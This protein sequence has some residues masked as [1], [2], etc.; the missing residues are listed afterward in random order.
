MKKHKQHLLAS[1]AAEK[2]PIKLTFTI[3]WLRSTDT[4]TRNISTNFPRWFP[5][6]CSIFPFTRLKRLNPHS[7]KVEQDLKHSSC[8]LPKETIMF[9]M[10]DDKIQK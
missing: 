4:F 2:Q 8:K 10:K 9:L 3:Y 7:V 6:K 1:M 5:R